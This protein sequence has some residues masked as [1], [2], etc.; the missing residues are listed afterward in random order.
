MLAYS[1]TISSPKELGA[2]F[3]IFLGYGD[4]RV[5][6]QV[7]ENSAN[8]LGMVLH[9]AYMLLD[10]LRTHSYTIFATINRFGLTCDMQ[11]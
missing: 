11:F 9:H 6:Y 5:D 3:R 10:T 4:P 8:M 2:D 1:G 7:V